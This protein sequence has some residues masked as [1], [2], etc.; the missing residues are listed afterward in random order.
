MENNR[1]EKD[2]A[3]KDMLGAFMCSY[4]QRDTD[5]AF[6]DWLANK[7]CQELGL[8]PEAGARLADDIIGAVADYDQT[9][10]A[11]NQAIEAGQSKEEWLSEQL[12]AVYQDMPLD[13]AGKALQRMETGLAVSNTQLI[14]EID[15]S[16]VTELPVAEAEPVEWNK[17]SVKAK[18]NRIGQQINSMV[19]CAAANALDKKVNG[20][21]ATINDVVTDAFQTGLKASPSEVKAVVAGAV[22][23]SAEKGLMDALPPDTPIEVIG[24]FAGAAVEGAEALCDAANGEITITEAMDKVGRAG[25]AAGCRAG[26]GFLRGWLMTLPYGPVLVDLLEGLLD[27]MGSPQ[28][29]NNVYTTVRGMAVATWEGIKQSKIVRGIKQLGQKIFS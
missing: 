8:E 2:M 18:A 21:Q 13:A 9:L 25:V 26:A 20:E 12:E 17:Y 22:R 11:L 24:D 15:G 27:H 28:F 6:P 23:A 1:P 7:L 3:L 29:I 19:L 4:A 5:M 14:G 10:H 16:A